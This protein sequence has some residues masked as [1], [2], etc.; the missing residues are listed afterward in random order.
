[1]AP[2]LDTAF[3]FHDGKEEVL[4]G[5]GKPKKVNPRLGSDKDEIAHEA[6]ESASA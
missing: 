4:S 2:E 6:S 1:M 3:L 5:K